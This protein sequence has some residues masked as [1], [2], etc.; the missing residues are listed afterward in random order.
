VKSSGTE[1]GEGVFFL[2]SAQ[3]LLMMPY[4]FALWKMKQLQVF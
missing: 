1:L 4:L 2:I 3:T